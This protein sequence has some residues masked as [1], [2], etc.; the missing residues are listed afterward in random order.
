MSTIHRAGAMS[1][2][3][4]ALDLVMAHLAESKG[5]LSRLMRTCRTL[6]KLGM[7]PLI[8]R[9]SPSLITDDAVVNSL[10]PPQYDLSAE[11][12]SSAWR[13]VIGFLQMVLEDPSARAR[14][15]E[16][17][18]FPHTSNNDTLQ[19]QFT[20]LLE[21][22]LQHAANVRSLTIAFGHL[23]GTQI[24]G[25]VVQGCLRLQDITLVGD[26]S[27]ASYAAAVMML[28]AGRLGLR[29]ISIHSVTAGPHPLLDNHSTS[30]TELCLGFLDSELGLPCCPNL[31]TLRLEHPT[32]LDR[33]ALTDAFPDLAEL[34]I[35]SDYA[36]DDDVSGNIDG[37][38][39]ENAGESSHWSQLS[40]VQGDA[41]YIYALA[42]DQQ[43]RRL[44]LDAFIEA[45]LHAERLSTVLSTSQPVVLNMDVQ[46]DDWDSFDYLE[47]VW[48]ALAA[49]TALRRLSVSF[50]AHEPNGH[51][52]TLVK[53]CLY[54]LLSRMSC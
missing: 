10:R 21:Q 46:L 1:L 41:P 51:H 27:A 32:L 38:H 9:Y 30:L 54:D 19:T 13:G 17:F 26:T 3:W 36:E 29:S 14:L 44:A 40:F 39:Q 48:A 49:N 50:Y 18:V 22:V 31:R 43:V 24:S 20:M 35:H 25:S 42:L 15:L 45:P 28:Q 33:H 47:E 2:D 5:D 16:L 37:W 34:Y 8:A 11:S 6:Y 23:S 12:T 53:V 7:R 4:D 52:H